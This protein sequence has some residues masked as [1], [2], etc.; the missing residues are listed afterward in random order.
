MESNLKLYSLGIVVETKPQGTDIIMVS[1]IEVLNIQSPGDIKNKD[2]KFEG[3]L[4]NVDSKNFKT[5]L[6][7]KNYLKAKWLPFGQSNRITAP[8]VVANE[9]VVLFKYGDVDEYY[10][11]TI[12]RE[13]E[14]RRLETVLYGFSNIKGGISAFDKST[15]Y[16]L[17]VDT[18]NKS[19]KFHTAMNDGEYTEYDIIINTK[20]G[21]LTITDKK[22]NYIHLDSQA[23]HLITNTNSKTTI[24][25]PE[26]IL[27]GNVTITGNV[28]MSKNL[29]VDNNIHANGTIIDDSGNTNHHG[30]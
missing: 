16:W 24:N 15:S 4:K 11:I 5:E 27:N 17:E 29:Q 7:A 20:K 12:F 1:P 3:S 30:H 23:D 6:N 8:D 13:V 21:T 28:T 2:T 9:T 22:K 10:W 14:L 18:K 25:S 19:V 26:I